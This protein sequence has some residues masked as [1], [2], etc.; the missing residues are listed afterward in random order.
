MESLDSIMLLIRINWYSETAPSESKKSAFLS[1]C[2][3]CRFALSQ[4]LNLIR[5]LKF[6]K[7]FSVLAWNE[8]LTQTSGTTLEALQQSQI[9]L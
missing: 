2:S 6:F 3:L 8:K 1:V 4:H 5:C 9:E 7:M